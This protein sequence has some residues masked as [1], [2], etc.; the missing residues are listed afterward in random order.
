MLNNG[1][2]TEFS[3][4]GF[5][6]DAISTEKKHSVSTGSLSLVVNDD[7]PF[8]Q[9]VSYSTSATKSRPQFRAL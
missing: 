6:H 2:R 1:T 7:P 5:Q 9:V 8:G 3:Q 4:L